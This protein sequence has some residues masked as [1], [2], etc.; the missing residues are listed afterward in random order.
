MV[1]NRNS[2]LSYVDIQLFQSYLL[3]KITLVIHIDAGVFPDSLFHDSIYL[4][5][6]WV[7]TILVT[8]TMQ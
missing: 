2:F 5:L 8:V 6:Y 7:Y 1:S 3:K 4:S